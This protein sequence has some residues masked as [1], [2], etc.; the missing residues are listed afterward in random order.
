MTSRNVIRVPADLARIGSQIPV[1]IK[2]KLSRAEL[3]ARVCHA[4]DLMYGSGTAPG[5]QA[6]HLVRCSQQVLR[7]MPVLEYLQRLHD[8]SELAS[9][10]SST[11]Q[12]DEE[13]RAYSAAGL[14]RARIVQLKES[15][16]YPP[17]LVQA[18]DAEV[19]GKPVG[20]PRMAE[21]A[22]QIVNHGVKSG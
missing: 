21:T 17:G 2:S 11:L 10:S 1:E 5:H 16:R 19:L 13:G 15:N 18:V 3:H 4:Q 20:D 22:A 12:H 8:L 7:A 6:R 9:S 14:H